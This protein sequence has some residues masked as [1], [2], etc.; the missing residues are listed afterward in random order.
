MVSIDLKKPVLLY[1]NYCSVCYMMAKLA[2]RLSRKRILV[3]GMYTK[4]AD[5]LKILINPNI[6]WTMSWMFYENKILGGRKIISPII[7]ETIKGLI[8]PGNSEFINTQPE[9]CSLLL[10]CKGIKGLILRLTLLLT[11]SYKARL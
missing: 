10:P 6:Y 11:R 2:W 8:E 1:D 9:T 7:K 5:P 4:E 3:L